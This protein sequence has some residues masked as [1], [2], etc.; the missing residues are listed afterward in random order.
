M[1]DIDLD[2]ITPG[3]SAA[4]DT[5]IAHR[6]GSPSTVVRLP[7]GLAA[8]Q[9]PTADNLA[10]TLADYPLATDVTAA[11]ALK[12]DDADLVSGLAGKVDKDET[13]TSASGVFPATIYARTVTL[14]G[15]G[16]TTTVALAGAFSVRYQRAGAMTPPGHLVGVLGRAEIQV[17]QTVSDAWVVEGRCDPQVSGSNVTRAVLFK[18]IAGTDGENAGS[19]GTLTVLDL[20][21]YSGPEYEYVDTWR[22]LDNRHPAAPSFH[23]GQFFGPLGTISEGV[24]NELAA[25]PSIGIAPGLWVGYPGGYDYGPLGAALEA[26]WGYW[27][28]IHLPERMP[29]DRIMAWVE[30]A[31]TGLG[32]LGLYRCHRGSPTGRVLDAGTFDASTTGAKLLTISGVFEA[33]NYLARVLMQNGGCVLR[34]VTVV[35]DPSRQGLTEDDANNVVMVDIGS[36][37]AGG[38]PATAP[39]ITARAPGSRV[40]HIK[41]RAA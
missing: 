2:T 17:A 34:G 6:P 13:G 41:L 30:T 39:A 5:L 31:G 4:G 23:R 22:F 1:A 10:A 11:L 26:G 33:G 18:S 21:D 35:L 29:A 32:A 38:M 12:A 28:H 9:I 24:G 7:L 16:G 25:P 19:I 27:T 15:T 3:A 36:G 8:G 14:Q 40:P 20:P 37:W